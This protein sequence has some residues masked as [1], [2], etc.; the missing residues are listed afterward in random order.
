MSKYVSFGMPLSS[1]LGVS[2]A[3]AMLMSAAVGARG[4]QPEGGAISPGP[5]ADRAPAGAAA[6]KAEGG[7]DPDGVLL[8]HNV[9]H[10][11]RPT[12]RALLVCYL[13]HYPSPAASVST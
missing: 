3:S 12:V 6:A 4:I 1:A 8:L 11:G 5:P 7:R 2:F 13:G 9:L 10:L